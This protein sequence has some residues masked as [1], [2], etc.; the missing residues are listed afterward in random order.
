MKTFNVIFAEKVEE[1][2]FEGVSMT[3]QET[4]LGDTDIADIEEVI[5]DLI[6]IHGDEEVIVFVNGNAMPMTCLVEIEDLE[7]LGWDFSNIY[8]DVARAQDLSDEEAEE[9]EKKHYHVKLRFHKNGAVTYSMEQNAEFGNGDYDQGDC[10]DA[11]E[12]QKDLKKLIASGE[13]WDVKCM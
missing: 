6:Q 7:H 9:W 1:V 5:E 8:S 4:G 12:A 10:G 3:P 11:A 13:I 2:I